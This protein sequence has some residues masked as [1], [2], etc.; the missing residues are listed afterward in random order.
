MECI[1]GLLVNKGEQC[2]CT[3]QQLLEPTFQIILILAHHLAYIYRLRGNPKLNY[4]KQQ[5]LSTLDT[6]I[7]KNFSSLLPH[8]FTTPLT[9]FLFAQYIYFHFQNFS[10][11]FCVHEGKIMAVSLLETYFLSNKYILQNVINIYA[12]PLSNTGT[13]CIT[14]IM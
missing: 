8:I 2:A 12:L 10:L 13:T 1:Y 11:N 4:S 3:E 9:F 14:D 5:L 6:N 7:T